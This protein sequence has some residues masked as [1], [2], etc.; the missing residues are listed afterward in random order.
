MQ[1]HNRREN[2]VE[3]KPEPGLTV[4]V[5]LAPPHRRRDKRITPNKP[6]S[7]DNAAPIPRLS[8]LMALAIKLQD[9]V[10]RGE[11]LD[12]ADLARLGHV[13]RARITQIMNLLNLAPDIQEEILNWGFNADRPEGLSEREVRY[14][15]AM[16][17]WQEQRKHWRQTGASINRVTRA[18]CRISCCAS[19]LLF[20][21]R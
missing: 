18:A 6:V 21:A 19:T 2:L 3:P 1:Q 7:S 17:D 8:R 14:I 13:S 20:Q 11:V 10:D 12:Y 9:M 15:T 16:I 5:T 4:E